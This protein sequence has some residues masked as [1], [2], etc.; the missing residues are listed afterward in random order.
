MCFLSFISFIQKLAFQ[1]SKNQLKNLSFVT[2][3]D[4]S[5]FRVE[6]LAEKQEQKRPKSVCLSFL[7]LCGLAFKIFKSWMIQKVRS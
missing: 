4:F 3:F 6:K 7:L 1:R 2:T 5:T